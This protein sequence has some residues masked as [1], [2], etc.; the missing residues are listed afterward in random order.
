RT[1]EI[2]QGTEVISVKIAII[3]N[4]ITVL[5][6]RIGVVGEVG[7]LTREGGAR[8]AAG[9]GITTLAAERAGRIIVVAAQNLVV[10]AVAGIEGNVAA[11]IRSINAHQDVHFTAEARVD[12]IVRQLELRRI[13]GGARREDVPQVAYAVIVVVVLVEAVLS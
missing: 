2:V 4:E 5:I 10:L 9:E 11:I 6:Y 1:L 8:P 13:G 12:I 3:R 7:E